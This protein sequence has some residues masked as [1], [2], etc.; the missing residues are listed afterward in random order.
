MFVYF[1]HRLS[2]WVESQETQVRHRDT[3]LFN[4]DRGSLLPRS[5]CF[6]IN[7]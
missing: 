3:A 7:A 4:S 5:F 2:F 1:S 6:S